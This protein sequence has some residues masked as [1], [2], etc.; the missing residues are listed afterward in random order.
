MVKR[1]LG[2]IAMSSGREKRLRE[3][4]VSP[5]IS[6][7]A[8]PICRCLLIQKCP[9]CSVQATATHHDCLV[10][11]TLVFGSCSC[12]FHHHCLVPWLQKRAVC[13]VHDCHWEPSVPS[14]CNLARA[15]HSATHESDPWHV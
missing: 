12:V 6:P 7:S 2:D 3:H 9:H 10:P 4:I 8:C 13:P 5:V 15:P 1:D 11:C 14:L